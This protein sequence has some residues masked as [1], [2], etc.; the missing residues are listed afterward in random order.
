MFL[1]P[2]P[3]GSAWFPYVFLWS[4]DVWAFKSIYDPTFL[5][6]VVPV[7]RGHEKGF[8]GVS[9]F[10]MHLDPQ[11]VACL[12]EPF[13]KSM[14]VWYYY[15]DGFVVWSIVFMVVGLVASGCLSIEDVAFAV[16]FVL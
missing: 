1:D 15:G 2:V 12:F 13:L 7:L 11:V 6:L 3:E 8:S 5:K 4:V 10:E 9:P 14:D 16:K